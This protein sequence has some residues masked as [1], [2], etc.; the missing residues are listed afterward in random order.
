MSRY[1]Q[2]DWLGPAESGQ[3]SGRGLRAK[4][5]S[6]FKLPSAWA[7]CVQGRNWGGGGCTRVIGKLAREKR[8][9][10]AALLER[11]ARSYRA[12]EAGWLV[13]GCAFCFI[14]IDRGSD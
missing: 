1:V 10:A 8:R 9:R 5:I 2:V 13:M 3:T 11:C 4:D 14:D 7:G 12:S 6:N